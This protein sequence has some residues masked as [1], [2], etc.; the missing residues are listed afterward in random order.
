[1]I[2]L[3]VTVNKPAITKIKTFDESFVFLFC[4]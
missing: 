2:Y 4:L 1:M 3:N